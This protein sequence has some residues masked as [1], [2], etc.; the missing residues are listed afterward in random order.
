MQ[1]DLFNAEIWADIDGYN[2]YQISNY[3]RI[4]NTKTNQISLGSIRR[5]NMVFFIPKN[6]T[7]KSFIIKNLVAQYFMNGYLATDSIVNNDGDPRNNRIEN[8]SVYKPKVVA[9]EVYKDINGFN[10]IYKVSNFGNVISC[11]TN[12][13]RI[14]TNGKLMEGYEQDGFTMIHFRDGKKH[15]RY[16]LHYLVAEYFMPDYKELDKVIHINGNRLDNRLENLQLIK[17]DNSDLEGEIW[18]DVPTYIGIYQASNLGRIKSMRDGRIITNVMGKHYYHFHIIGTVPRRNGLVHRFVALAFHGEPVGNRKCVNHKD[19][20]KLNNHADNLEWCTH[21]E[22]SEHAVKM[23]LMKG[24]P[25][26][27]GRFGKYHNRSKDFI[28]YEK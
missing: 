23:G 8:L 1:T 17:H 14:T 15:I 3:G 20:N 10:G 26:W 25:T 13:G 21:K 9:N 22:N 2:G 27:K 18:K 11:K 24:Y 6:N 5:G 12:S 19:G 7:R 16:Y 4:K 28:G